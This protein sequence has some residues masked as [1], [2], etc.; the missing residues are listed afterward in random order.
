MLNTIK[1]MQIP[2]Y[3][4]LKPSRG[5]NYYGV[6]IDIIELNYSDKYRYV[7]FKCQWADVISGRGCKK[8]DFG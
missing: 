3:I 2:I 5:M 7:L 8:D 6:L 4:F 1:V